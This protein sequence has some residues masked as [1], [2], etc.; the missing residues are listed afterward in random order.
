MLSYLVGCILEKSL[1]LSNK[2]LDGNMEKKE[3]VKITIEWRITA[4]I[5]L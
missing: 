5:K 2:Y 3:Q 4:R 1:V